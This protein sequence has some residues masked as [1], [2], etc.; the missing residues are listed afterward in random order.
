MNIA[1]LIDYFHG[2]PVVLF[3]I[4][5]IITGLKRHEGEYI[6]SS[7]TP[8]PLLKCLEIAIMGCKPKADVTL[9]N[10]ADYAHKNPVLDTQ[11]L[12]ASLK[13]IRRIFES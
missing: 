13:E 2:V 4:K 11:M 1:S 9:M 6:I 10:S 12:D 7:Y 8:V 5:V 3:E